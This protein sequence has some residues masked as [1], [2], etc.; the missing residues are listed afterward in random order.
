MWH[1]WT[2]GM[3]EEIQ[4]YVCEDVVARPVEVT[5]QSFQGLEGLERLRSDLEHHGIQISPTPFSWEEHG[6]SVIVQGRSRVVRKGYVD[7]MR[8]TWVLRFRGQKV[9]LVQT[10]MSY[11]EAL[12]FVNA[13]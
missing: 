2:N 6:E 9:D 8:L 7:D 11:E 5:F 3:H 12:T 1:A 13:S 4:Q 10:C